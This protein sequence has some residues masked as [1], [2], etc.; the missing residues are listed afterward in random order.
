MKRRAG[1]E[2]E[3]TSVLAPPKP[4]IERYTEKP[5]RRSGGP[6]A[7]PEP[8]GDSGGGWGGGRDEGGHEGD[9]GRGFFA[10]PPPGARHFALVLALAGIGTL[11]GVFLAAWL[12]LRRREPD[13]LR[14]SPLV[15]PNALWVSTLV[16]AASSATIAR[17]ALALGRPRIVSRW[18]LVSL[19]LGL[20]FLCAQAWMWWMLIRQGVVPAT[21]AYGAIFFALTGLHGLHVLGGLG[22]MAF[23]A[24]RALRAHLE[25]DTVRLCAVYWHFMG[26]L[27]IA[28]FAVLY[29]V[30]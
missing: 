27:W 20:G 12:F 4:R 9:E 23:A 5:R 6:P 26:L 18:L 10:G 30:R 13:V 11:F 19:L 14:A 28:I 2:S 29:F 25:A 16:L 15:P 8:P 3:G 24:S 7:P 17:A 21:G 1:S 22:C